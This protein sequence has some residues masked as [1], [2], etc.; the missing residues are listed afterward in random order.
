MNNAGSGDQNSSQGVDG[1]ELEVIRKKAKARIE[2]ENYESQKKFKALEQAEDFARWSYIDFMSSMPPII[3]WM[4]M[5]TILLIFDLS[6][7]Q[8]IIN[9]ISNYE[10]MVKI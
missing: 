9:N 6:A 4:Q 7:C 2:Q 3:A 5:N 1:E 8:I 10:S